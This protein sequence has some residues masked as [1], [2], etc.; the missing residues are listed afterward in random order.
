MFSDRLIS[1]RGTLRKTN[2]LARPEHEPEELQRAGDLYRHDRSPRKREVVLS[3]GAEL[4]VLLRE[5]WRSQH[6]IARWI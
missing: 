1:V 4:P 2:L 6:S 3:G 5:R